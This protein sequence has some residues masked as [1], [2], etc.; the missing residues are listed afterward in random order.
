MLI[1]NPGSGPVSG[2]NREDAH[3]NMQKFLEDTESD[4]FEFLQTEDDG[5]FTY[6][7]WKGDWAAEIQMPGLPLEQVRYVGALDQNIWNFPRI[8]VDGSS[9]VWEYA[10]NLWEWHEDREKAK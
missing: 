9:W 1:N 7:L 2:A 6:R 5:R 8:Y 4:R 10:K 3:N